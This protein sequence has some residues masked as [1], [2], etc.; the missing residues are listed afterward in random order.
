MR[1][2][3]SR[4]APNGSP[5]RRHERANRVG[6]ESVTELGYEI[7]GEQSRRRRVVG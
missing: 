6:V 7:V 1:R 4:L 5:T 3:S 2:T